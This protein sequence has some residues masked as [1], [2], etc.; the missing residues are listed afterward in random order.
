M[1][2]DP[3]FFG[4]L[5]LVLGFKHAFDVDHVVAVSN[6]LTRQARLGRVLGLGAAWAGGHM[7][8][9]A[10]VSSLVFLFAEAVLPV[11][12][13]FGIIVPF[14]LLAIG[15]F[16]I[17][18]EWRRFHLHRHSHVGGGPS[19]THL[20]SHFRGPAHEHGAMAG[21]GVVHGLASNDELLVVLL[22]GLGAAN[23]WQVLGGVA[24]FSLGV[25]AGMVIYA[26]AIH[27][28]SQAGAKA[29]R[30]DWFPAALTVAF[31]V[32]SIAY[33]V[34]LLLGGEG[35]NLV[36]RFVRTG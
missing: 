35:I 4:V 25:V 5:A 26:A 10:L 11:T 17:L 22:V 9:A 33:G 20:H 13:R 18:A 15:V 12:S 2:F 1:A 19:H 6:L 32:A 16:G 36:N 31:S 21:I 8:T 27:F 23:L 28:G 30:R 7:I 14:M 24:L 29:A 34:Y 3:L